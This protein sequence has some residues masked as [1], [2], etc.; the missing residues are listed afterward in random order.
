MTEG[1]KQVNLSDKQYALVEKVREKH[2]NP[3]SG[4]PDRGEAIEYMAKKELGLKV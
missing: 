4:K 2:K 1:R 3:V